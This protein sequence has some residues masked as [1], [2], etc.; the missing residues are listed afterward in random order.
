MLGLDTGATAGLSSS[1][2]PDG[3]PT[4]GTNPAPS[5]EEQ[6]KA[7]DAAKE[8]AKAERAKLRDWVSELQQTDRDIAK[9]EMESHR[10][11]WAT[12]AMAREHINDLKKE[13]SGKD[14]DR[15]RYFVHFA[16]G[17]ATR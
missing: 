12:K 4:D 16:Q 6:K 1:D 11:L 2:G 13:T 10:V 3:S 14:D 5:A 9:L 17:T 15:V 7:E 8:R